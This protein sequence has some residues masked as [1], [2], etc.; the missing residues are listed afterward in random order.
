MSD[1]DPHSSKRSD[2]DSQH[3]KLF[4]LSINLSI[5]CTLDRMA[6]INFDRKELTEKVNKDEI[7]DK[8]SVMWI[9]IRSDPHS[10]GSVDPDP[11]SECRSGS[12]G[13]IRREKQSLTN[14]FVFF[15]VKN[16]TFQV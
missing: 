16:Y 2:P 9:R 8:F 15:F 7:Y 11:Y 5:E 12:R 6:V 4:L 1:P 3:W 14:K 13:I 10:F